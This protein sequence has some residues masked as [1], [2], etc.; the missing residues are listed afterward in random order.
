MEFIYEDERLA[1]SVVQAIHTGDIP[2]LRR[3]L[4]ENSGLAMTRIIERDPSNEG[5]SSSISR[6]LFACGDR[7]ARSLPTWIG[8]RKVI[9]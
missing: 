8:Y 9:S 1:V 4:A 7:L 2:S 6:T 5:E 3:L